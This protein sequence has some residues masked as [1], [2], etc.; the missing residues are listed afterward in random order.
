MRGFES[1]GDLLRNAE[2]FIE[3]N[4]TFL[5]AL[6]Q[7]RALDV[8]HDEVIR[9]NVVESTDIGMIQRCNRARLAL[10]PIGELQRRYFNGD[11]APELR[12]ARS[13]DFTHTAF[14]DGRDN[15]LR[16]EFCAGSQVHG[17]VGSLQSTIRNSPPGGRATMTAIRDALYRKRHEPVPTVGAWLKRVINGYFEYHAVP[18]NL[19]RLEGFR[20]EVCRAWRHALLRRSQGAFFLRT[21]HAGSC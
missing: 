7:R 14:A 5:N 9:A 2:R 15:F 16:A 18:T 11:I 8:L 4:R 1:V 20:T 12:I 3:W 6:G 19:M 10:E 17:K 21:N 13:P